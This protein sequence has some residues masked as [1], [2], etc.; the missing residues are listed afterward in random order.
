LK[1]YLIG[2]GGWAYFQVPGLSSLLAYSRVFDFVEVNSTFYQ[3]PPL[4]EVERWRQLVPQDFK[5]SVRAHRSITHQHKLQPLQ[6]TYEVLDR[7]KQICS[8]LNADILH[9]QTPTTFRPTEASIDNL[10]NF[11]ASANLGRLRI[12]L[13]MR[14]VQPSNLPSDLV[15]TMQDFNVVHSIDLSKGEMPAYESDRLYARLFGKGRHNVYQPTDG[16]LAEIDNKASSGK[17][18]KIAMSFHFVRMYKDAARLKVYKQT[19]K[20]PMVTRSTGVTSLEEVLS[21]DARFPTTKQ[22]LVQSQGWKL[23][24]LSKTERART[25]DLLQRLPEGT[26]KDIREVTERVK[27]LMR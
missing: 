23:F 2:T 10:R 14:G 13:E 17:S 24:D 22:E 19:G 3:I 21:E 5:F 15:K 18:E 16:E 8:V 7:M 9:L 26:Y 27:Q 25:G 4:K 6:E 20:F 12:A 1:E 11:L